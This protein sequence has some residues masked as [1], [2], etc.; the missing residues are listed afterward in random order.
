MG[1]R[2]AIVSFITLGVTLSVVFIFALVLFLAPGLSVF[3]IKYIAK[4]T[5]VMSDTYII[6]EEMKDGS[7]SGSIRIEV[8]EVPVSVVFTQKYIYQ[9]EYYDN[10]NGL[11]TSKID[12]PSIE[13][14]KDGDGTAVVKVTS[15][16]K[17]IYENGNS[18]RYVRLLI[19]S[20]I[21]GGTRA[22]ETSL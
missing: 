11:T 21:V 5:H 10:Y 1:K 6:S 16:K 3:G 14:S 15:F 8:D 22:G 17:F 13:F 20:T 19:P 9:L 12:D 2:L 7:F 18:T 4:S